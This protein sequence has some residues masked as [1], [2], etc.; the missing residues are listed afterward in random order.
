MT[1]APGDGSGGERD[2]KGTPAVGRPV[3][4]VAAAGAHGTVSG[5]PAG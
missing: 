4:P 1:A 5:R 3:K 2:E